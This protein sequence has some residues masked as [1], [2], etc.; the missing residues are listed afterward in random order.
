MWC[1]EADSHLKLLDRVF[2]RACSIAGG[3]LD[4]NLVHRRSAAELCMIFKIK[5]NPMHLLSGALSL[6]Y[7]LARVTLGAL[8]AHIG[9]R[10]CLPVVGLLS[11][12]EPL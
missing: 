7:V 9:T 6:P 4:C 11:I 3:V 1:S 10:S 12:A 8:V 2:R 5:S